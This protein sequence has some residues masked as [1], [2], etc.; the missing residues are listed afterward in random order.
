[1]HKIMNLT[2]DTLLTALYF[3]T[4]WVVCMVIVAKYL[5]F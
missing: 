3:V 2:T 5:I 4:V 1:M